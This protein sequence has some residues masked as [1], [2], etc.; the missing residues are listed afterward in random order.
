MLCKNCG[1]ELNAQQ[2]FCTACGT[3]AEQTDPYVHANVGYNPNIPY[4]YGPTPNYGVNPNTDPMFNGDMGYNPV[5]QEKPV[6]LGQ[7]LG[8]FILAALPMGIGFIL[9]IV[10]ACMGENKSRANFFRA[11]LIFNVIVI[12]IVVV[13]FI[14]LAAVGVSFFSILDNGL[15]DFYYN[16]Y[17]AISPLFGL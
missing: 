13:A 7:Y 9:T 8:W 1:K 11:M 5:P 2:S 16:S 17:L 3:P 4:N 10:F 6:S 12:A 14:V 15:D